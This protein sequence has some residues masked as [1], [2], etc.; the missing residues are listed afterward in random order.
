MQF[1]RESIF[2][3]AIRSFTKVFF[4][5]IGFMLGIVVFFFIFGMMGSSYIMPKTTI[6]VAPNAN[7]VTQIAS[8]KSPLILKI[9]IEGVIGSPKLN[10]LT[11]EKTLSTIR[12]NPV[13]KSRIKGLMLYI[14]S[15]GG[16]AN[17]S[18][19]IYFMLKRFKEEF[20]IPIYAYVNGFCASGAM[21][22]A[23]AA[24]QIYSNT[25]SVIGSVGVV[26]GP[27]FNFSKLMEKVG[28]GSLTVSDGTGKDTLNPFRPWK[29]GEAEEL[30]AIVGDSYDHFV[31]IVAENR[32]KLTVDKL[33]NEFGAKIFSSSQAEE[34]GYID[35]STAQYASTL[36][37]LL[38]EA[39]VDEQ[40]SYQVL[41][42]RPAPSILLDVFDQKAHLLT[43]LF[44]GS[45]MSDIEMK[46]QL[47]DRLLFL[48]HP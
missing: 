10:A 24:D 16:A 31:A 20:K 17:D 37:A 28:I 15:P 19:E 7:G 13:Y 34:Y 46:H 11:I 25:S 2:I 4:G 41:E 8:D 42:I 21:Y 26:W 47:S 44:K 23:C 1:E 22:I 45:L 14:N 18:E 30:D 33:K 32:P 9:N 3:S 29:P 48:Y 36:L 6:F 38:K 5:F 12:S 43:K 39:N 27:F 35:Q 40:K